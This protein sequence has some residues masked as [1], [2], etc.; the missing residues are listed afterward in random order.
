M[1]EQT[2]QQ[3]NPPRDHQGQRPVVE[4]LRKRIALLPGTPAVTRSIADAVVIKHG[5]I[6]LLTNPDGNVPLYGDH[7]YGLYYRD[8]RYLNGYEL[9]VAGATYSPL[10]SSSERGFMAIFQ[11]VIHEITLQNGQTIPAEQIGFEW[12]HVTDG[13]S[14]ALRDVLSF[15]HY[16]FDQEIE[17]P[18]SLA[19]RAK[20]EDI[21]VVRGMLPQKLGDLMD[22]VWK[23]GVLSLIYHGADG[24]YRSLT[25]HFSPAPK[26]TEGSTAHFL[27]NLRPRET[28]QITISLI[29]AESPDL[30]EV[31]PKS[32]QPA[33]LE[34]AVGQMDQT[35]A[36]WIKCHSEVR[37]DSPI[38]E[39]LMFR[40]LTDLCML[41]TKI[42]DHE[43]FAAGLPWFATLFGRDSLITAIQSLAFYPT[44][45]ERTLRLLARFQGQQLDPWRDEQPGKILHELRLGEVVNLNIIP[46]NPYYGTVDATPLFLALVGLHATWTGDLTLFHDLRSNIEL[47]FEWLAK[48]GDE[49]SD[50]FIEYESRSAKGLVNQGWKDSGDAIVD[51]DGKLATPPIAVAEVQGYVYLAK[52][53]MADVYEQAGEPDRA[54]Q[55]RREAAE[56]RTKFNRAFWLEDKGFYALALQRDHEPCAVLASNPGQALWTG[57]ADP[58]KARKMAERLLSSEM[59]D[60]WGVRTLSDR[61]RR[62]NPVGYHVGTIW[63]HDNSLIVAGLRRY[64]LDNEACRV[65]TG[66]IEAAL[67]FDINRLPELFAGFTREAYDLPVRYPVAC[68]PQAWAA[69]AIPLMVQAILGLVP[70]AFNHRL[71]IVR[72][73][74]PDFLR[75]IEFKGLRVGTAQADLRFERTANGVAVE[76]LEVRG[77]LDIVRELDTSSP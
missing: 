55:L 36:D 74:F 41:K 16:G 30:A 75:F 3:A 52:I 4:E 71:R 44:T 60:G 26:S 62:Y 46:F 73:V 69:G 50:G 6:F 24:L 18:L 40:S 49:N 32:Y 70:D 65:F 45:A 5:G 72:P 43:F 14:P 13:D 56:L 31:K 27:I 61:E 29:L 53:A 12:T 37:S 21:F 64:G 15:S 34:K 28:K 8:C 19:F 68:H 77:E 47:A 57:I 39:R 38:M 20:F 33:S 67:R 48:Y 9:K 7:G 51:A 17:L 76:I 54:E 66:I 1:V 42:A 58:D 23:N 25:V 35:M 63:P 59:F 2:S 11:Y 10:V 22:P